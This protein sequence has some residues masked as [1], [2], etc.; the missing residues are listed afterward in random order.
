MKRL[1]T[2][3]VLLFTVLSLG[4]LAGAAA[5]GHPVLV[6]SAGQSA[7]DM[8]LKV[9]LDRQLDQTVERDPLARPEN[10]KGMKTLVLTLGVSNK[11]L[12]SAGIDLVGE[13]ARL[14]SILD[15]AKEQGIYVILVHLGGPSRR[16]VSSDEVAQL[17]AP[18]VQSMIV[19]EDS[20]QDKFFDQLAEK[21]EL[22]AVV[23]PS[24]NDV[25]AAIAKLF[26]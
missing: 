21:Y 1:I 9:M 18:Y 4:G 20:N 25:A 15:A 16:G 23:V 5:P 17:A 10:L 11:G 14:V 26:E 7:D 24:R 12:G 8:I 22:S 6:T 13:K 3:A 2:L 19:I